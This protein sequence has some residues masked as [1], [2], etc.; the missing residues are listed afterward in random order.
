MAMGLQIIEATMAHLPVLDVLQQQAF[1]DQ[2][3]SGPPWTEA[4]IAGMLGM[5]GVLTRLLHRD[6]QAC[7]MAMWRAVADEAELLTI[8]VLPN[9]RG[10]GMGRTLL[11]DGLE[12][13]AGCAVETV[14]LEVAVNNR[15][16][17]Q[18][19][20]K[21]GFTTVGRRRNYY[22]AGAATVDAHVMSLRISERKQ[23]P[24][25]QNR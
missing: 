17:I 11:L 4:A 8:G 7:G 2:Q 16:A 6:G 14:F 12:I 20:E 5:P 3:T 9:G 23:S 19:Y 1:A 10:Q 24:A 18:L 22:G 13:L 15:T 25:E 21:Q